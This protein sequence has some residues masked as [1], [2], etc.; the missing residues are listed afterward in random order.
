MKKLTLAVLACCIGIATFAQDIRTRENRIIPVYQHLKKTVEQPLSSNEFF[1]YVKAKYGLGSDVS[2]IL[3]RADKDQIGMVHER[4]AQLYNGHPVQGGTIILHLR[5]NQVET[6][7]GDAFR[8]SN[9]SAVAVLSASSAFTKA[10]EN[11]PATQYAWQAASFGRKPYTAPQGELVWAPEK[12]DVKSA[13]FV[14]AWKFDM[15]ALKPLKKA[16]VYIDATDGHLVWQQNSLMDVRVNATAY[17]KYSG[18]RQMVT[19]S[20][21]AGIYNLGDNSRGNGIFTYDMAHTTNNAIEFVNNNTVWHDTAG[22]HGAEYDAHWGLQRVYDFY[23]TVCQRSSYDNLGGE[24]DAYVHYDVNFNNAFW[25]GQEIMFGDGDLTMHTRPLTSLDIVGHE[26]THGVTQCS[27][28]LDYS[29]EPGALNESFSDI[30]GKA[31]EKRYKP[32]TFSWYEAK[33]ISTNNSAFRCMSNPKSFGDPDTYFGTNYYTGIDDNG[34]VHTNSGVQNFWF[35]VLTVGKSG[36]N[37]LGDVYNVSGIGID[38]ATAIAYRN[39]SLYLTE[40]SQ[41]SDAA[42]GAIQAATDLYGSCSNEVVQTTNAWYAVG[43]SAQYPA[44]NIVR[45]TATALPSGTSIGTYVQLNST[46]VNATS[47]KWYKDATFVSTNEHDSCRF[48]STGLH[49]VV[50]VASNLA[51]SDTLKRTIAVSGLAVGGVNGAAS[52][53]VYPNPAN[54]NFTLEG[55]G[56]GS[57]ISY[58]LTDITGKVVMEKTFGVNSG[59]Y[60]ETVNVNALANGVYNVTVRDGDKAGTK[61][62]VIKN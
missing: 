45:A 34:G 37:D 44:A 2:F 19:E 39:L 28:A 8:V 23:D 12:G 54:G 10:L 48:T 9:P 61:Q 21:G 55:T 18:A 35:Y 30:M 15:Y 3:K 4:Y 53:S 26:F 11:F 60:R 27:A 42:L 31:M 29:D 17:T 33:E 16:F 50:L 47:L 6:F 13:K 58:S 1:S 7:N 20:P 46:T 38:K 14:L 43:L 41:Y 56:T 24:I 32:T 59:N 36:T 57:Q 49:N 62:L 52:F 5:N 22:S 25:D 40:F 51:C